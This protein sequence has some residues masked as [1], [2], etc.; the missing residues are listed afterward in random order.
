MTGIIIKNINLCEMRQ[1]AAVK[2]INLV[3]IS[4]RIYLGSLNISFYRTRGK[5]LNYLT[6]LKISTRKYRKI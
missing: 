3:W 6:K 4:K 1:K 2:H 5:K